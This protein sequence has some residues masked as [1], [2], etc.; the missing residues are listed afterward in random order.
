[1]LL[2]PSSALV[3]ANTALLLA[4][5]LYLIQ[6]WNPAGHAAL[7]G[8]LISGGLLV[9]VQLFYQQYLEK[10]ALREPFFLLSGISALVTALFF[11][12]PANRPHR[13]LK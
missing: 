1:M 2:Y 11:F 4:G 6:G 12:F 7:L 13:L 5:T 9:L 10:S 8:V 3:I